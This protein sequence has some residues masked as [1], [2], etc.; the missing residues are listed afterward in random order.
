MKKQYWE[1]EFLELVDYCRTQTKSLIVD[2]REAMDDLSVS[3]FQVHSPPLLHDD[4]DDSFSSW[5]SFVDSVLWNVKFILSTTDSAGSLIIRKEVYALYKELKMIWDYIYGVHSSGFQIDFPETG[6]DDDDD[7]D[8]DVTIIDDFLNHVA[9]V[10]V[11]SA[12]QSCNYWFHYITATETDPRLKEVVEDLHYEID[13]TNPKFIEF[14]LHFFI[15]ISK[16]GRHQGGDLVDYFCTYLV[17]WRHG[18]IQNEVSSLLTC[19]LNNILH[20]EEEVVESFCREINTV[21]LWTASLFEAVREEEVEEDV[22]IPIPPCSELLREICLLKA[23]IFLKKLLHHKLGRNNF[24]KISSSEK[25]QTEDE[26]KL[27][28][29]NLRRYS[30]DLPGIKALEVIEEVPD[31]VASLCQSFEAKKISESM[32]KNSILHLLLKIMIVRAESFLGETLKF[33]SNYAN[34]FMVD[35]KDQIAFLFDQITFLKAILSSKLLMDRED[36]GIIF[37]Q[38]EA[39][40]RGITCLSYSNRANKNITEDV[41]KKLILSFCEL[42]DKVQHLKP[43]LIAIGPQFPPCKFPKNHKPGFMDFPFTNLGELLEYYPESI[44]LVKHHVEEIQ[45]HLKSLNPL[46]MKVSEL[47]IHEHPELKDLGDRV[48]NIEY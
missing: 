37:V 10:I 46:L 24:S 13:T 45:V 35:G 17:Q 14:H 32:L 7:D 21:L 47:D 48:T 5:I 26:F 25:Y 36:M 34:S 8:D 15:A 23:E 29:G 22:Y 20:E 18:G 38:I 28:M 19:F 2:I 12:I 40:L 41:I 44:E 33:M 16:I 39:F 4:D 42:V 43:M 6:Y 3:S 30:F 9:S 27:I 31:E 11:R 1:W